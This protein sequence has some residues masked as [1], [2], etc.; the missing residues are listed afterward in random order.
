MR[1]LHPLARGL[2]TLALLLAL[3][4]CAGTPAGEAAADRDTAPGASASAGEPA[5]AA[6]GE[7][8]FYHVFFRSFRDSDG[9][10]IG[11][12]RGM[13]E[14]LDYLKDL[15][16]TSILLTPLQPSPFYHNYFPTDFESIEPAYGTMDDYTAFIRA[17]HA[18]GLKVYLDMEIQYV[19]EGHPWWTQS[20]GKPD[21]PFADYLL[22]R[23][24]QHREAEPFL[25]QPKWEGYDGR[26]HGIAMVNMNAPEVR[27]YFRRVLLR[28]A[29]PHGD[30]S[31]RDGPDGFRIDH[32]MDDLDNKHLATDLFAGFWK[33]IFDALRERRPG[34]RIMAEQY[35]WGYGDDWLTRGHADMVFAFPLRSAIVKLDKAEVLKALR[36]TARLTPAGKHQIVFIENHDT[37][38]SLSLFEGNQAKARAAA[39]ISLLVQGEPLIHYGQEI[40]MRGATRKGTMSDGAHVPLRE[41][42][43]WK[44][45]LDAPGSATWYRG[46]ETLWD[47]RYNRGHDEFS[48]EEEDARP[49]S[50][51]NWYRR[52]LALRRDRAELRR[53]EQ[54]LPCDDAGTVLCVLREDGAARTLLLVNLSGNSALPALEPAL[55]EARWTDLVDPDA[56]AGR[57][58]RGADPMAPLPP[59]GVRILAGGDGASR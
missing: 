50:L 24:K 38:R 33:P 32:M 1:P 2:S 47:D 6:A 51:L 27:D 4:G 21:A 25:T 9:D 58:G 28:W 40:G 31:G 45:D 22:W 55:R 37:D 35:D 20:I 8:V 18:R 26:W 42:F 48:V 49:D 13:T 53:G 11:D 5:R 19:G 59:L 10:R 14:G 23:D 15:G 54:R 39:A 41:A 3:A 57:D 16:V 30:G 34:F 56:D 7:E 12:L 46:I 43:R 52:L 17:A 36:E 44:A 29:D